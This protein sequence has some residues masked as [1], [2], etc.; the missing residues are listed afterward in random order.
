M[1]V[2]RLN[3]KGPPTPLSVGQKV[4]EIVKD[5]IQ[6][7]ARKEP[8]TLPNVNPKTDTVL[9]YSVTV[10]QQAIT[11]TDEDGLSTYMGS[12]VLDWKI[13]RDNKLKPQKKL[14]FTTTFK[15][16]KDDRGQPDL[17]ILSFTFRN[18]ES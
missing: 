4:A 12:G 7:E 9:V 14:E 16:I 18:A 8:S 17:K 6:A 2:A 10:K 3:R 5:G 1:K 11:G 13:M 15:D